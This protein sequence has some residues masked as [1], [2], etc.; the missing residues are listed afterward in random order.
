MEQIGQL[1]AQQL[2][3]P[4]EPEAR[5][6]RVTMCVMVF[7]EIEMVA[8]NGAAARAYA[9]KHAGEATRKFKTAPVTHRTEIRKPVD[10]RYPEKGFEWIEI[11]LPQR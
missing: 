2:A 5:L 8:V 1:V 6:H 10:F 7:A 3:A 9:L 4:E 11:D